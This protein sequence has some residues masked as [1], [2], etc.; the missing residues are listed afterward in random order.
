MFYGGVKIYHT[1]VMGSLLP[2]ASMPDRGV[3][4]FMSVPLKRHVLPTT[5]PGTN[6]RCTRWQFIVSH[7]LFVSIAFVTSIALR[8][9]L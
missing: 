6:Y 5:F 4:Q 1:S 8:V 2:L 9:S 3:L 7:L